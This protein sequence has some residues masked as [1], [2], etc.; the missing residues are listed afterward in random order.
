MNVIPYTKNVT[1]C[2][3]P[4]MN[5]RIAPVIVHHLTDSEVVS[6]LAALEEVSVDV[7]VITCDFNVSDTLAVCLE[8]PRA[9]QVARISF[10]GR[11][12]G[13]L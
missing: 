8:D 3:D 1:D 7:E 9:S 2:R 10:D 6:I 5:E 11:K 12:V 4:T 13:R